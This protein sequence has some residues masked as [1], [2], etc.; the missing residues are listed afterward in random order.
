M[1]EKHT[2]VLSEIPL[3]S[4]EERVED[5]TP[6]YSNTGEPNE[7]SSEHSRE[8][9]DEDQENGFPTILLKQSS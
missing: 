2:S 4:D 3:Y 9:N 6:E 1:G 5:M 7:E 8:V